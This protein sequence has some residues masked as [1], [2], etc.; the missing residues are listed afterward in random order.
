MGQASGEKKPFI[1]VSHSI[2]GFYARRFVTRY[3]REVAG[4]V[5]VDSSHE[6]QHCGCMNSIPRAGSGRCDARLG[7]Y[8]NR[9]TA[10]M[11]NGAAV[12]RARPRNAV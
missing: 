4:L 3:P 12:D 7:F 10:G 11:A 9:V 8:V 6:E 1:L 5:F 2:S